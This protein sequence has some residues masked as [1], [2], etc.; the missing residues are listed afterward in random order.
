MYSLDMN[1]SVFPHASQ[2]PDRRG[3]CPPR[4]TCMGHSKVAMDNLTHTLTGLALSRAGFNRWSRYALPIL[5]ISAN[6]PD[7]DIL[8]LV[9]G[10]LSYF[11]YH[12]NLT[13]ALIALP[14]MAVASLLLVRLFVWRKPF[15]WLRGMV[16][17]S[18]GVLSHILLDWTNIYG[19][20]MLLPFSTEW[21]RLDITN[22]I[23]PW[24]WIVLGIAAVWPLLSRL[25]SSEIG[26]PAHP[27]RGIAIFALVLLVGYEGARFLMHGRAVAELDARVYQLKP[28]DRVA[29]FATFANPFVWS[30]L[31]ETPGFYMLHRVN[32]LEQFDPTAGRIFYKP[33][34]VPAMDAAKQTRPFQVFLA[35]AQY[36]YWQTGPADEPAGATIV[37]VTDLRFGAPPAPGFVARALVGPDLRVLESDFSYGF[38]RRRR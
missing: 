4:K 13:H 32:L 23:D 17:A 36:P 8:M 9:R 31:V 29:A 20:R 38:S 19:I 16:A 24:I 2:L 7:I 14:V 15:P 35:F 27:G 33:E 25:V 21:L 30:G 3:S 22:I 11:E 1:C 10:R 26:A 12:R 37:E 5:L 18:V 34:H 28:P 6:V